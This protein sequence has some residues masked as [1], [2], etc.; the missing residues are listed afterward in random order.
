MP[1]EDSLD[2]DIEELSREITIAVEAPDRHERPEEIAGDETPPGSQA[3]Q[4]RRA[5]A[6]VEIREKAR[7]LL[8]ALQ[9]RHPQDIDYRST[10][11]NG[12]SGAVVTWKHEPQRRLELTFDTTDD[13]ILVDRSLPG[14]TSHRGRIDPSSKEAWDRIRTAVLWLAGRGP[15]PPV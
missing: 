7:R 10:S 15:A 9:A 6:L 11:E 4:E 2:T 3:T 5:G 12:A 14:G 13:Q 8:E 1:V